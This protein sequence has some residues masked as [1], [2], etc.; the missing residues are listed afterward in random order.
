M[1]TSESDNANLKNQSFL[2][3]NSSAIKEPVSRMNK[4]MDMIY[5]NSQYASI[6]YQM[7]DMNNFAK[8]EKSGSNSP[9]SRGK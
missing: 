4:I 8:T 9:N 5:A 7:F 2:S 1:K 6:Y 3:K